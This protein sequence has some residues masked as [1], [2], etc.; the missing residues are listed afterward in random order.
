MNWLSLLFTIGLIVF[1]SMQLFNKLIRRES[2]PKGISPIEKSLLNALSEDD[3]ETFK[4]VFEENKV[5]PDL[6]IYVS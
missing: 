3:F 2:S 6:I 5:S 1:V 4:K